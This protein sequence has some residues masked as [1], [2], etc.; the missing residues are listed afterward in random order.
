MVC[1]SALTSPSDTEINIRTAEG[2]Y[3]SS[4][5]TGRVP[6]DLDLSGL[7]NSSALARL[8][9]AAAMQKITYGCGSDN[10]EYCLG[11]VNS[12]IESFT[13]IKSQRYYAEHIEQT[14]YTPI[15]SGIFATGFLLAAA[16][17]TYMYY[18]EK[19][20]A[21]KESVGEK[22]FKTP[23]ILSSDKNEKE[24]ITTV[25]EIRNC[26]D[27]NIPEIKEET[28]EAAE[29]KATETNDDLVI[30]V[31]GLLLIHFIVYIISCIILFSITSGTSFG[32]SIT[33][34]L[35]T[36]PAST[37]GNLLPSGLAIG[38]VYLCAYKLLKN[39]DLAKKALI[40][41]FIASAIAEIIGMSVFYSQMGKFINGSFAIITTYIIMCIL[42]WKEIKKTNN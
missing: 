35:T 14:D 21:V 29:I 12:N 32:D 11:E 10:C 41:T 6:D 40:G 38:T 9:I 7:S 8:R 36:M 19:S 3:I 13:Y 27:S 18:K 20:K 24:E 25:N 2:H 5:R 30:Y 16:Y 39:K 31:L 1:M 15:V 23:D 17:F 28:Y 37:S 4:G 22:V 26:F 33:A 34:I 42:H